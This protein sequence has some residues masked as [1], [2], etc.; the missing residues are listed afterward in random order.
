MQFHNHFDNQRIISKKPTTKEKNDV[1]HALVL[2]W[3]LSS[4]VYVLQL[5][6]LFFLCKLR[7]ETSLKPLFVH[8]RLCTYSM[9]P[10]TSVKAMTYIHKMWLYLARWLR[11]KQLRKNSETE[12]NKTW[13]YKNSSSYCQFFKRKLLTTKTCWDREDGQTTV[14]RF[15]IRWIIFT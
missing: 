2:T 9:C 10:T 12:K 8:A 14:Y 5:A 4:F 6:R 7:W 3:Q 15:W 11:T 13:G 1:L